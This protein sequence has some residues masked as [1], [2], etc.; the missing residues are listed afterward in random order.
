MKVDKETEL[1]KTEPSKDVKEVAKEPKE[2]CY[3]N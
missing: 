3:A 1:K 2:V